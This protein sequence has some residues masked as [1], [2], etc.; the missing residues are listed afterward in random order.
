MPRPRPRRLSPL[1]RAA[2]IGL[3]LAALV[4][5]GL[6]ADDYFLD[7]GVLVGIYTILGLG[8]S[9]VKHI[10]IMHGGRIE[11]QSEEGRGSKFSIHL[12]A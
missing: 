7:I 5:F 6:G 3:V 1:S 11:V 4:A 10:V 12:P 2:A 8:L 9:I